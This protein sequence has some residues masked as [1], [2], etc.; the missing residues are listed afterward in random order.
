MG[1]VR[2]AIGEGEAR[3]LI[4]DTPEFIRYNILFTPTGTVGTRTAIKVSATPEE[5]LD[6]EL[7]AGEWRVEVYGYTAFDPEDSGDDSYY[8][9]A[10]GEADGAD[11]AGI[12]PV[13]V[14]DGGVINASVI[15]MP[16]PVS[17][18]LPVGATVAPDWWG[19]GAY[20]EWETVET[21]TIVDDEGIFSYQIRYPKG[22][23]DGTDKS[24]TL[25]LRPIDGG[26]DIIKDLPMTAGSNSDTVLEAKTI[27][28]PPGYYDMFITLKQKKPSA[29]A[30]PVYSIAGAYSAVHIYAGMET[31]AEYSFTYAA[32]FVDT[33]NL[34]GTVKLGIPS[35]VT[36][37]KVQVTAY[38]DEE[39]NEALTGGTWSK[40]TDIMTGATLNNWLLT[41]PYYQTQ[42]E[43]Y[44]HDNDALTAPLDGVYL[45]VTVTRSS[46]SNADP[47]PTWT[48]RETIT[49]VP[50]HYAASDIPRNGKAGIALTMN[51]AGL[52]VVFSG[53]P[54]DEVWDFVNDPVTTLYWLDNS[55]DGAGDPLYTHGTA[56]TITVPETGG[57]DPVIPT[58][59][60]TSYAWYLDYMDNDDTEYPLVSS[61]TRSIVIEAQDFWEGRHRLTCRV[62]HPGTGL[63]YS[64]TLSF[65]VARQR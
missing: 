38:M 16:I 11:T 19:S 47:T 7:L 23:N 17:G 36:V 44:D 13:T 48:T 37:S 6:V 63:V 10:Y 60:Y 14:T 43:N 45:K 20:A 32:D 62:I 57:T 65:T 42:Y 64:K 61:S 58:P 27:A 8:L 39:C 28:V 2:L 49:R 25:T 21:A 1:R 26:T 31:K 54:V 59:T 5:Y 34:A 4:P 29:P 35:N 30:T 18:G 3:T 50:I 9:A 56:M 53:Q 15:I 40:T 24:G 41:V 55:L 33:V 51:L 52:R 46:H 22:V 12:Q